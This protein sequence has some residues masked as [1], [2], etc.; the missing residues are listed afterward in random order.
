MGLILQ[1]GREEGRRGFSKPSSPLGRR[2][3]LKWDLRDRNA[4][5]RL[6]KL[7]VTVERDSKVVLLPWS[8]LSYLPGTFTVILIGIRIIYCFA[9]TNSAWSS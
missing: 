1:P 3:R 5:Y 8:S 6:F 4:F 7:G 9:F 2:I